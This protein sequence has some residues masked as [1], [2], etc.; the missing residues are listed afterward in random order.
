MC[1]ELHGALQLGQIRSGDPDL[2]GLRVEADAD[3][4]L[5]VGHCAT[6]LHTVIEFLGILWVLGGFVVPPVA[7]V[8]LVY[9]CLK[10][11]PLE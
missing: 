4:H 2:S 11:W 5:L 3:A 8:H 10:T 1:G 7:I 9:R 6:V